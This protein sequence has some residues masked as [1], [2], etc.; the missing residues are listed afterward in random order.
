[1]KNITGIFF[2]GVCL[3]LQLSVCVSVSLAATPEAVVAIHVSELTQALETMPAVAPTPT[4]TG[5]TGYQWWYTAWRYFVAY[6]SLK[7]ALASDGTPY[8]LVSD[9]DI[10]AGKL[11]T[12]DGTP[13]YP[14][15]ISLAAEA[16]NDSEVSPLREYVNAGGFLLVGSSS[17]T[18]RPDGSYRG[19]FALATEMGLHMTYSNPG[20]TNDWNW[21]GNSRLTKTVD[22]RLTSHLPTGTLVW[23]GPFSAEEIPWGVSPRHTAHQMHLAFRVTASGATVLANGIVGPLLA[24][25]SYGQGYILFNGQMQPVIGHGASDPSLYTYLL[26]RKAI[27]WAFE[28]F[29][30]PLVKVS[31]WRYPY[32]AAFMVRHD[33]ENDQ[34]SIRAIEA[35]AQFEKSVGAKGD[36]FFSTGALRDDMAGDAAAITGLKN[37][38]SLYGAT[39]GSHNGGLKNPVNPAL[40]QTDY[41]Y[42]HWGPDEALDTTPAG[43]ANGKAYAAA[44]ILKSFEDIE[45]WLVGLDNG[46]AGCGALKNCP[47]T[48]VSPFFNST[49]EG[50]REA[51]DQLVSVVMGEQRV[52]PFPSRTLSYTTAGKR[53]TPV[54]LPVSDWFVGV[55]IAQSTEGHTLTSIR[56]GIDFYHSIGAL[57]NFYTHLPSNNGGVQQE[58]VTYS[59]A[60]PRLWST[61]AVEVNDWWRKRSPVVITPT[62][63]TTATTYVATATVSGAT[64]PDTAIEMIIPATYTESPIVYL[65]GLPAASSDYR[66]TAGGLKIRVGS[67]VTSVR[68]QN[69]LNAPPVAANDS[70]STNQ[71]TTLTVAVPGVL[72]NDSDPAGLTLTA[73]KVTNP[74]H[75]TVTLNSN[76]SFTYIPT[77]GY[78]GSDSFT[79][80]ASD[81]SLTSAAA[82]VSLTVKLANQAPIAAGDSYSTTQDTVLT[83]AAPGVLANDSDP[84]GATLT[85]QKV[86]NPAHGT[87]TLNSNGSFTYIPT[88]GYSGSDSFTYKASDGSLTSAAATVSLTVNAVS[89]ALFSDDFTRV[90]LSPWTAQSGTW[91]ITDGV[92]K[93]S[94]STQSYSY[95]YTVPDPEWRDY[96]VEAKIQLPAG[97]FGGGIG[98]RLNPGNGE[99]YGAWIYPDGSVG[100]ANTL[101]LIKFRGWTS[102]SGTPMKQVSLASV[103]TGW[104][105]LKLVLSG[106]R[107][108]VYYDGALKI[109]V[110]DNNFDARAPYGTGGI[111]GALWT[112]TSSYSMGLDNITVS[113]LP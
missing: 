58:Y 91:G 71:N 63:T 48:W 105:T 26:F 37:A 69:S 82:T 101:K 14:I 9:S 80:K 74:S 51:L 111:T 100:G 13:R 61:N 85:A 68:V 93:G 110:T 23:S 106:S 42:W 86:T 19:D 32:D 70:Y 72:A 75:G 95:A 57:I 66:T 39:I 96:S 46:K 38:V 28:T 108:Q 53:F 56:A 16:I 60:K 11:R 44:S 8:V 102:W 47:R 35:S 34:T 55:L 43:Y 2:V 15:L 87:V 5:T 76:G 4:G 21:Y 10:I 62:V 29:K 6:E 81:G 30:L 24:V 17:F 97:A 41:D 36:Y 31:P 12:A 3:I 67:S 22:H 84:E 77:T 94:G 104:H 25:N 73:Q 65:N 52:S 50:S 1:M 92:L 64:D 33:F 18:R 45:G 40:L 27:E 112:Y 109:D 103:G 54:S 20:S 90:L 107:I 7:E 98:G 88:T 78:S 113:S 59:M 89:S 79:Y 49:R 99:H 83:V